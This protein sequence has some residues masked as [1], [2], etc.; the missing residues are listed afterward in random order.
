MKQMTPFAEASPGETPMA[1]MQA[2]AFTLKRLGAR[3]LAFHGGEL[4]MAMSFVPGA[5][6]WY[7]V[8][9]YR[10]VD[11]RF[12]LAVKKFFRDEDKQDFCRAWEFDDFGDVVK[13]LEAYDAG[14]DV[15]VDVMPDDPALSAPEMAAHAFALRAKAAEARRQFQSLVGEILHELEAE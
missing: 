14:A 10:T 7:E 12:V 13:A 11:Q 5:P 9:V 3:P 6:Y 8:N 15:A 1:A 2:Q 4:C